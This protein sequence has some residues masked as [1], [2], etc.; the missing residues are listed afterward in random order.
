MYLLVIQQNIRTGVKL[1]TCGETKDTGTNNRLDQIEY[2]IWNRRRP[3]PLALFGASLGS[4]GRG[5]SQGRVGG[6]GGGTTTTHG[7]ARFLPT[8]HK[9]QWGLLAASAK[10]G[11]VGCRALK[12][13]G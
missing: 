7:R 1:L 6:G 9:G 8:T 3:G 12:V 4:T 11:S 2:L 13:E 10:H 5:N